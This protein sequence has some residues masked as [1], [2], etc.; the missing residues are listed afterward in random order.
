V[1]TEK[2]VSP[3]AILVYILS[4]YFG[5]LIVCSVLALATR[6]PE[7]TPPGWQILL[8]MRRR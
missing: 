1:N 4:C 6:P 7:G 5:S 8:E 3:R 2:T